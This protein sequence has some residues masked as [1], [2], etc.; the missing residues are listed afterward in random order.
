MSSMILFTPDLRF[1]FSSSF[2]AFSSN[3]W[4]GKRISFIIETKKT[5]ALCYLEPEADSNLYQE[6]SL[7]RRTVNNRFSFNHTF[8][9]TKVNIGSQ[10]GVARIFERMTLIMLE[11]S[12]KSI[13]ILKICLIKSVITYQ[14]ATISRSIHDVDNLVT[15][16]C[17]FWT[18][19]HMG[20]AR[21]RLL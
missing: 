13:P 7:S 10:V 1:C 19:F 9:V 8:K 20:Q 3:F 12:S 5:E 2:F 17:S 14:K 18:Y 21:L 15:D 16:Y 11:K 4:I 6:V